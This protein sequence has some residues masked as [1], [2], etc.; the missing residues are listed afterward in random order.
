[1]IVSW[2]LFADL[3]TVDF[4]SGWGE[5]VCVCVCGCVCVFVCLWS[6]TLTRVERESVG[7]HDCLSLPVTTKG[8]HWLLLKGLQPHTSYEFSLLATNKMG[9]GTFVEVVPPAH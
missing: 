2:L 6:C 3:F 7:A 4:I 1:M 5:C 8:Q 9:T